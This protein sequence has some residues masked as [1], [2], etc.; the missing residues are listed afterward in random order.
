M[1]AFLLNNLF[2]IPGKEFCSCINVGIPT[3]F[4][5]IRVGPLAK[6]PVPIATSGLNCFMILLAFHKLLINLKAKDKLSTVIFL[7]TPEIHRPFISNPACGI[8]SISILSLAPTN[9][10]LASG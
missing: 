5:T 10:K 9:R 2:V 6:P 1:F 8:F 4:A 7:C 3:L